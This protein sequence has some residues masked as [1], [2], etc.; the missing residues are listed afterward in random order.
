M[1]ESAHTYRVI[2]LFEEPGND[3]LLLLTWSTAVSGHGHNVL[4][5]WAQSENGRNLY[6]RLVRDVQTP[7]S[8]EQLTL[9]IIALMNYR[10]LL[11]DVSDHIDHP[12]KGS[13]LDDLDALFNGHAVGNSGRV[14]ERMV[15]ALV[16]VLESFAERHLDLIT[17]IE[18]ALDR[19]RPLLH[20]LDGRSDQYLSRRIHGQTHGTAM[21][22][23]SR[24]KL[25]ELGE[26]DE[27]DW[28]EVPHLEDLPSQEFQILDCSQSQHHRTPDTETE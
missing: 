20:A 10:R 28:V 22:D 12:I 11:P 16:R 6:Q 2:P 14:A 17:F 21:M 26:G 8:V 24:M 19:S 23:L 15:F 5:I 4:C 9:S 1:V 25:P 27:L 7:Q 3:I 18:T 13:Y